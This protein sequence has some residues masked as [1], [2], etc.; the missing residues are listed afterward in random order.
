MHGWVPCSCSHVHGSWYVDRFTYL[1]DFSS[2]IHGSPPIPF[3][4]YYIINCSWIWKVITWMAIFHWFSF[5]PRFIK[6]HMLLVQMN[7]SFGTD[8]K[9]NS[10]YSCI[11][12]YQNYC[13]WSYAPC[14]QNCIFHSQNLRT[15]WILNLLPL[16]CTFLFASRLAQTQFM[17]GN[18]LMIVACDNLY[19]SYYVI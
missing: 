4:S 12:Q 14:D 6:F 16:M 17:G 1:L 13:W 5:S 10:M 8:H 15:M 11:F 9:L 7:K 19:L 18:T 3:V 2:W